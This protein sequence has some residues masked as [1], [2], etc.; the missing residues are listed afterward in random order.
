MLC[1][2]LNV[3]LHADSS[4]KAII[5]RLLHLPE[6]LSRHCRPRD[7]AI[8]RNGHKAWAKALNGARAS[9][10]VRPKSKA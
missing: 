2:F 7:P 3:K 8:T 1:D 10:Q 5:N 6:L 9:C 4:I